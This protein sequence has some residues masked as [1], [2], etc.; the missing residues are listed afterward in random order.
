MKNGKKN[1]NKF[2]KRFFI[3]LI[4]LIVIALV[5]WMFFYLFRANIKHQ[6]SILDS[7]KKQIETLTSQSEDLSFL[8]KDWD[9]VKNYSDKVEN[10]ILSENSIVSIPKELEKSSKNYNVDVSFS[11]GETKKRADNLNSIDFTLNIRGDRI[12]VLKFFDFVE[13]YLP[14]MRID[15]I[16]ISKSGSSNEYKILIKGYLLFK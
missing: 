15:N 2:K 13:K 11:F 10:L 14:S 7:F 5:F 9:K 12:Y 16:D 3:Q 8:I 6:I 1:K 4:I